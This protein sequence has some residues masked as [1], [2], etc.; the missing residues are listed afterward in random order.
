LRLRVT[1]V[2]SRERARL[3]IGLIQGLPQKSAKVQQQL[4]AYRQ[5]LAEAQ[6]G[7]AIKRNPA[8]APVDPRGSRSKG[9]AGASEAKPDEQ[10]PK[11]GEANQ[12]KP[13]LKAP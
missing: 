11:A 9:M 10:K 12:A 4:T 8:L 13:S 5:G 2:A 7:A 6:R 1:T 3:A